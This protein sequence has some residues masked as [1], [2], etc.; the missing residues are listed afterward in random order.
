MSHAILTVSHL[1]KKFTSKKAF[2]SPHSHT[3]TALD[4]ISFSLQEGEILGF[5]GPNGA[6]K[7]TTVHILLG[8]LTPT[9]GSIMYFG[10]DFYTQRAEIMPSIS[11]A[12]TY[13]KLPG[14]LT[15]QENLDIYGRLYGLSYNDRRVRIEKYLKFFGMWNIKDKETGVLSAGQIT[16]V[17][18]AKVFMIHPKVALLDEPTASLDPDIAHDVRHF[19]LDQQ[20][21]HGTSVL[22]TSHNMDE[23]TDICDRVLV[24]QRGKII[25]DNTPEK[26]A[27]SVANTRIHFIADALDPLE[28][29]AQRNAIPFI[30]EKH[31]I[32]FE[33]DEHL[34]APLLIRLAQETILY[35]SISIDKPTLEDYFLHIAHHNK[36]GENI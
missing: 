28:S 22:I 23:V 31:G 2:Y 20:K 7:T 9:S 4:D 18:L 15:V 17:M 26:L 27:A 21:E 29:Y 25:A 33:L 13:V 6:G 10:K 34:I 5:L 16:R 12:S 36:E 35:T 30:R 32:S 14:R 19:I 3:F 11:F 1:V 24:L 8:I